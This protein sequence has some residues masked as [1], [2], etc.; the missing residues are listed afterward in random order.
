[1]GSTGRVALSVLA[2]IV[3]A[4]VAAG[5]RDPGSDRAPLPARV[6][7]TWKGAP[8]AREPYSGP[9]LRFRAGQSLA[10]GGLRESSWRVASL[11]RGISGR[12]RESLHAKRLTASRSTAGLAVPSATGGEFTVE[13]LTPSLEATIGMRPDTYPVE[14]RLGLLINSTRRGWQITLKC[15]NLKVDGGDTIAAREVCLVEDGEMLPLNK[16]RKLVK[17]GPVGETILEVELALVT[18]TYHAGGTYEGELLIG[19]QLPGGPKSPLI[20]V[21]FTVTVAAQVTHAYRDHKMYFHFGFPD[22]SLSGTMTGEISSD[23]PLRLSLSVADGRVDLLPLVKPAGGRE[24]GLI[25]LDWKLQESTSSSLRP[26]DAH[27]LDWDEVSWMLN[28]TPGDIAYE[29]QCTVEPEVFQAPG[30]YG[31]PVTLT[32]T[33]VL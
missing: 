9:A 10:G 26:P 28:G 20:K 12:R 15:T 11:Y 24:E 25:P 8:A 31:M 22:E 2:A 14:D 19:S 13:L 30:D 17:R 18:T 23:A 33:P 1:M 16:P 6:A 32:L 5:A 4:T 7:L 3:L 21:P 29:L 27:S